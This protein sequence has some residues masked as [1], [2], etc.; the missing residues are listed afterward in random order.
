MNF[1]KYC[2]EHDIKLNKEDLSHI[3]SCVDGVPVLKK[4]ELLRE[5][6][7]IYECVRAEC[8]D[9]IKAHNLARKSANL[10]LTHLSAKVER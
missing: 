8:E 9:I 7:R 1:L 4:K 3:K 5:Y 10:F 6:L 2:E